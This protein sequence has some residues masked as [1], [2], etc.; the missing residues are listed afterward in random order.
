MWAGGQLRY[1]DR[2]GQYWVG[3]GKSDCASPGKTEW[4]SAGCVSVPPRE[5]NIQDGGF[6]GHLEASPFVATKC[7]GI[8]RCPSL[9]NKG[10]GSWYPSSTLHYAASFSWPR[11]FQPDSLPPL[12]LPSGSLTEVYYSSWLIAV[13]SAST[14]TMKETPMT[15][16]TAR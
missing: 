6:T 8:Y 2:P 10:E 12:R 16:R 13:N 15:V 5:D 14:E 4:G 7:W 11:A 1:G 9:G 3:L